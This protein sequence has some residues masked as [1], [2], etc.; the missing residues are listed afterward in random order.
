MVDEVDILI[1]VEVSIPTW[2]SHT[3]SEGVSLDNLEVTQRMTR[4]FNIKVSQ[5]G[6][7]KGSLMIKKVVDFKKKCGLVPDGEEPFRISQRMSD[8][9]YK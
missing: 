5:K 9:A 2:G 6:C 7:H 4:R 1:S 3:L 8:E